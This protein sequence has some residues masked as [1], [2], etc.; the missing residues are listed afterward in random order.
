[1]QCQ[2]ADLLREAAGTLIQ[3]SL[4]V[5]L[6]ARTTFHPVF[7]CTHL[8]IRQMQYTGYVPVDTSKRGARQYFFIAIAWF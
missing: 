6:L 4:V 8:Y 3:V 7:A 5:T 1:M 2:V